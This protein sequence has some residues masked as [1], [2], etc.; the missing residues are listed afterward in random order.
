ME[1]ASKKNPE[2]VSQQ[3]VWRSR[4]LLIG[5]SKKYDYDM[6]RQVFNEL[7]EKSPK[8]P[9]RPEVEYAIARRESASHI[10][11]G[12]EASL[13]RRASNLFRFSPA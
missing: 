8:T 11:M 10:W 12:G 4:R 13:A 9:L 5:E 1:V 3:F 2:L 7:L 6:A